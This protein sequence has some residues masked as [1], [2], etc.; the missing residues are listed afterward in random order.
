[1]A[2]SASI[3]ARL[4]KSIQQNTTAKFDIEGKIK[5]AFMCIYIRLTLVQFKGRAKGFIRRMR[6]TPIQFI[7][8]PRE[9]PKVMY[10]CY[11][12]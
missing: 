11:R 10:N 2:M 7:P 3:C 1:M 5:R 6:R 8:T 12:T 9:F 4:Y